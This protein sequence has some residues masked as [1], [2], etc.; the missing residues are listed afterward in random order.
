MKKSLSVILAVIIALSVSVQVL[1]VN[2]KERDEFYPIIIVAGYGAAAEYV[3][4]EDGTQTHA[5]GIDMNLI[6]KRVLM[7]IA[8]LAIGLGKLTKGDA[9]Y[10]ADVVGGE[11]VK[12]FEGLRCNPDGTSVYDVRKYCNTAADSNYT[13]LYEYEDGQYTFEPEIM[14]MYGSYIG[15]DWMDYI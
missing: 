10:V 12:M 8:D 13:Y 4:N 5:W 9:K 14:A 2:P 6:L 3:Q 15:D 7:R 1:A 11:F